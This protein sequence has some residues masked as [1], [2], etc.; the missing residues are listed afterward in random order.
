MWGL[1]E[2]WPRGQ[3]DPSIQNFNFVGT[4][5]LDT[6]NTKKKL[7]YVSPNTE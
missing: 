3:R 7:E 6:R 2:G 5:S 4:G 1:S